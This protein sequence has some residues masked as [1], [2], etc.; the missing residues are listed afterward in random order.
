MNDAEKKSLEQHEKN[1]EAGRVGEGM[2]RAGEAKPAPT[3]TPKPDPKPA[4]KPEKSSAKRGE[5]TGDDS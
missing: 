4:T 5:K 2:C 3:P 1:V